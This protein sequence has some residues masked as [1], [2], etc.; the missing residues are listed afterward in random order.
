MALNPQYERP[1]TGQHMS[2]DE[3]LALDDQFP[4][5]KYEYNDGVVRFMAG[6]SHEHDIIAF[7]ARLAL[8]QSF[9]NGP[10]FAVGS[11]IRVQV[12]GSHACYYPDVTVSCNVDDRRRGNKLIRSPHIIV[13][14]LSPSTE[15]VDR[16]EKL[17]NDQA[18]PTIWEIVL[19]SQFAVYVEVYERDEDDE[20]TW[21]H[22]EYT[23][24]AFSR[25]VRPIIS[26]PF[27]F[28]VFVRAAT[29]LT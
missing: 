21:N 6:G 10:C 23:K 20:S 27:P 17:R 5:L 19:I 15:D 3:Y 28:C 18:T 2:V 25:K 22:N 1:A 7:N 8:H 11:D 24:R 14:V 26:I 4:N 16:N 29:S 12:E 9:L 13:E